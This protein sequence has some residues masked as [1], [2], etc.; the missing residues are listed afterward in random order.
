MLYRQSIDNSN[1]SE[2]LGSEYVI[3][4]LRKYQLPDEDMFRVF[5]YCHEKGIMPLC[6]PWDLSSIEKL[7]NYGMV[8]F[9]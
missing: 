8:G 5:D 3:D 2:D 6:T 7:D 1:I 4:L 9:K